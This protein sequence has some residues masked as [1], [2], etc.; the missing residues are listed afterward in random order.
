MT[1]LLLTIF[2]VAALSLLSYA[3]CWRDIQGGRPHI[4]SLRQITG[5][6][7]RHRLDA[8]FGAHGR[9]YCYEFPPALLRAFNRAWR[10]Y[11]YREIA[12][13]G[14]CM[15]GAYRYMTGDAAADTVWWFVLLAGA[16]QAINFGYSI[17]LVRR[18]SHQIREEIGDS[19][20]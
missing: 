15:L 9:G 10:G 12:A 1:A 16:C 17:H 5:I 3:Y 2:I 20:E 19:E 8:I 4:I 11:C 18:W 14:V 7:D 6:M 13:D